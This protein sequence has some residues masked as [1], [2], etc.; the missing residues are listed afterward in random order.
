MKRA[1]QCFGREGA[2]YVLRIERLESRG[3]RHDRLL[4][5]R[6]RI[7]TMSMLKSTA[8]AEWVSAPIE[9]LSGPAAAIFRTF[10]SVTPPDT[11]IAARFLVSSTARL[12]AG[13]CM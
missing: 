12:M 4:P 7:G 10:A 6:R 1:P 9:I 11:S 2:L 5:M 13:A 8:G 3:R